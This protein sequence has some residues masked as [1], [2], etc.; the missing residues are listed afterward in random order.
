M[1]WR[2]PTFVDKA[3]IASYDID[4]S[5]RTSVVPTVYLYGTR[6]HG[7]CTKPGVLKSG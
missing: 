2:H 6:I 4:I 7:M 1:N 3:F 5:M